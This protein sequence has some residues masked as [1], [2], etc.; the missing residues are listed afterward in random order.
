MKNKIEKRNMTGFDYKARKLGIIGLAIFVLSLAVVLPIAG[1]ISSNNVK[2]EVEIQQLR[3]DIRNE[4][5]VIE[6]K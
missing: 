1:S 5:I 2:M 4:N 6:N 3:D